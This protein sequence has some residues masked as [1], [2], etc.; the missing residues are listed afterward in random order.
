[1]G[2]KEPTE[3]YSGVQMVN[4]YLE[5]PER[6]LGGVAADTC[7]VALTEMYL[8]RLPED[9]GTLAFVQRVVKLIV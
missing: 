5:R 8:S 9:V 2:W 3:K 4:I 6:T 7:S 1:M